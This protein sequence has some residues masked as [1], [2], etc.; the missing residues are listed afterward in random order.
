M[1]SAAHE[2]RFAVA[3]QDDSGH[4][5]AHGSAHY[6][7]TMEG[8]FQARGYAR[9]RR[10]EISTRGFTRAGCCGCPAWNVAVVPMRY[11]EGACRYVIDFARW[12][13][14]GAEEC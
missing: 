11:D 3:L 4:W 8:R 6:S 5:H 1:T 9:G 12:G 14:T 10:T 13:R 7:D 2:T